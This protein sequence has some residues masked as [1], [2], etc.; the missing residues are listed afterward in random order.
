MRTEDIV[1]KNVM[2]NKNVPKNSVK[3]VQ[4]MKTNLDIHRLE[5][6]D[7]TSN[8]HNI[9]KIDL[10]HKA[11]VVADCMSCAFNVIEA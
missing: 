8:M 7:N 6:K 2:P 1:N 4:T 10:S 5:Q 3:V 9:P 11:Y